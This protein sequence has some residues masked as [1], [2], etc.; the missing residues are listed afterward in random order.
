[1]IDPELSDLFLTMVGDARV[2]AGQRMESYKRRF[3]DTGDPKFNKS[4]VIWHQVELVLAK[5]LDDMH[6][7]NLNH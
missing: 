2:N 4:R 1:M 6:E 3:V 5:L 7:V